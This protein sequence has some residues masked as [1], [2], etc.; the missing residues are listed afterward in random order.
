MGIALVLLEKRRSCWVIRY[1]SLDTL[2]V[3]GH[4]AKEHE[5]L[6]HLSQSDVANYTGGTIRQADAMNFPILSNQ[7]GS[8]VMLT[9]KV[10]GIRQPHWHP[11]AWELN[12]VITG[13]CTSSGSEGHVQ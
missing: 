5:Y 13:K 10:D 12:F 1:E 7:L 9:L 3:K 4:A 6:F 2:P 11:F 8:M